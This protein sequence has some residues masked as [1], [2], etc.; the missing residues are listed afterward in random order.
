[1][2]TFSSESHEHLRTCDLR[3]AC[4]FREVVKRFDCKVIDGYRG[5]QMQEAAYNA[6]R[7]KLRFP[8]SKHNRNPS[9]AVDVI[10]YPVNWKNIRRFYY[11]GGY[12]LRTAQEL[13]IELRWGG[14]WDSDNDF[15][16][17]R[18]HDLLHWELK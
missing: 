11:F 4:V 9:Q 16:D 5:R 12:V 1:M 15:N 7:S 17:Q 3:L 18:F 10:P 6:K 2:P 8:D 13:G 14:D